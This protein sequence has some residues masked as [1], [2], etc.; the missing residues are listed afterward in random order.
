MSLKNRTKT[1]H[2]LDDVWFC[3]SCAPKAFNTILHDE[4]SSGRFHVVSRN[5]FGRSH[6][7][8][9]SGNFVKELGVA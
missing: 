7:D 3:H 9:I 2:L 1:K 8:L 6:V 5:D 4:N